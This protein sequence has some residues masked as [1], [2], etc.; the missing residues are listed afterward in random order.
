MSDRA[1]FSR[2][3]AEIANQFGRVAE[4]YFQIVDSAT[5]L[6]KNQFLSQIYEILPE[7]IGHAIHLPA[8]ELTDDED[9]KR[10]DESMKP[11]QWR[12]LYEGLQA[13]LG[14][15]DLYWEVFDPTKDT[16]SSIGSLADD[17]AD[18]YRDLEKGMIILSDSNG[19][20]TEAIWTWRFLFGSHW[21][22]HAIDALRTMH[23]LLQE[24]D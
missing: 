13:K 14:D 23:F 20:P 3:V 12:R 7:L 21:G 17:I 9:T 11:D 1:N 24:S 5:G 8:V 18:I 4:R 6:E 15:A 10:I 16:E 19:K 2:E 22:K